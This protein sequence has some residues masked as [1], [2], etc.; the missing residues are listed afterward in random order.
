MIAC[1][2]S[3]SYRTN[4]NLNVEKLNKFT[5]AKINKIVCWDIFGVIFFTV[6]HQVKIQSQ[7]KSAQNYLVSITRGFFFARQFSTFWCPFYASIFSHFVCNFCRKFT[8]GFFFY[9]IF[10]PT[11]NARLFKHNQTYMS[12]SRLIRFIHF[13]QC[14]GCKLSWKHKVKSIKAAKIFII[15][16]WDYFSFF[17]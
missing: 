10:I 16:R 2:K 9:F 13:V 11:E 15:F 7:K 12:G 1:K 8:R 17:Q 14:C 3:S 5:S 6:W 4:I